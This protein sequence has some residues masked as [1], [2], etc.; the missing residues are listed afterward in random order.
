MATDITSFTNFDDH[1]AHEIDDIG[2]LLSNNYK[3]TH[4]YMEGVK[5]SY[6][7]R[8]QKTIKDLLKIVKH[9]YHFEINVDIDNKVI[10]IIED[11]TEVT[12]DTIERRKKEHS[13]YKIN[14]F[15]DFVLIFTYY[16]HEKIVEHLTPNND[17]TGSMI[18]ILI[19]FILL[20]VA[21]YYFMKVKDTAVEEM[22]ST[23][24]S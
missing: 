3:A 17:S 18:M 14:N 13:H 1:L 23:T 10:Y 8:D 11:Q 4:P 21:L 9:N 7:F 16:N 6:V 22:K 2:F 12:K 19:I 5:R 24:N 20:A 15:N